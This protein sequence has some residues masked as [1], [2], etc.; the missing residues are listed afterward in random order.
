MIEDL[1]AKLKQEAI[2]EASH[3][4]WCDEQLHVNK[5]QSEIDDL[6]AKIVDLGSSITTLAEEQAELT[7]GMAERTQQRNDEHA[8]NTATIADAAAGAEAVQRALVILKEFYS[9]QAF[10]QQAQEPEMQA[11]TG[12]HGSKEGVLGMLE[13]IATDFARLK[14]DTETTEHA[15]S[16]DYDKYMKDSE[17]SKQQK[18]E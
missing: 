17:T 6:S 11:Y 15:A 18:H 10:L 13:V 1:L 3:K 9:G 14:A 5:L 2:A 12:M 16:T 8:E 7:K 4:A